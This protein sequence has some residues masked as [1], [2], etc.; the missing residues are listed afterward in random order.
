MNATY[1][2]AFQYRAH[3][4]ASWIS[5]YFVSTCVNLAPRLPLLGLRRRWRAQHDACLHDRHAHGLLIELQFCRHPGEREAGFVEPSGFS[6]LVLSQ[7]LAPNDNVVRTKQV[8]DGGF[9]D[10]V[11]GGESG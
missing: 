3:Y 8:E 11:L 9:G 5:P 2:A 6:D 10:A 1:L 7:W 4:T